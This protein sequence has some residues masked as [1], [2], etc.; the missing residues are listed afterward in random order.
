MRSDAATLSYVRAN[1]PLR[2][3]RRRLVQLALNICHG[4]TEANV[5]GKFIS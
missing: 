2:A 1:R 4:R 3:L 5:V